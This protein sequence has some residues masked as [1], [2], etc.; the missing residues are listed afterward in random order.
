MDQLAEKYFNGSPY[1]YVSNNPLLFLD[2]DG[3][4]KLRFALNFKMNSGVVGIRA[5]G[6]GIKGGYS[7]AFGG[8]EQK[9]S[10]YA[11]YDT[12]TKKLKFG[13]SHTQ[14]KDINETSFDTGTVNG[15]EGERKETVRDLNTA[16]GATKTEDK[17]AKNSSEAGLLFLTTDEEGNSVK[18][19]M[20]TGGEVNL[21]I[22]GIGA[23]AETSYTKTKDTKNRIQ[24]TS[25][26]LQE[27]KKRN[28][29]EDEILK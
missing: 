10:I 22:F 1:N 21:G 25:E 7:R 24:S 28:K 4:D 12:D 23:E 13:I 8:V 5:K 20:G 17:T 15:T 18:T 3:R 26:S 6:A 9:V 19:D 2:P 11:E 14:S 16:D 27:V 29:K